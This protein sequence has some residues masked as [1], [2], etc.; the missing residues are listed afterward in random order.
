MA[1]TR[2]SIVAFGL[3]SWL[4]LTSGASVLADDSLRGE[5]PAYRIQPGDL[6][7]VSVWKEQD[8]QKEVLVR[9]DGGISFPLAG[10]MIADGKSVQELQAELTEELSKLIP[11]LTVTVAVREILGNKIYVIG[12]VEEPGQFVVNPNVDVMQALSI[13]GG[14]T[15]FA[16]LNDIRIL[17]RVD[18]KQIA[19][20][21]KYGEVEDGENLEQ[22]IVLQSGDTVV[23]P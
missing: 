1:V 13:A 9:P 19:I 5:R 15:A 22:N 2:T 10:D 16:A 14:T 21:F 20:P 12:K 8:L 7:F 4:I 6:L 11:D 18:S 3:C 23:V 17:R